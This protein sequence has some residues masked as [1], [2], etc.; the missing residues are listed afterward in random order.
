M[1]IAGA[2][3]QE[4][5]QC[6]WVRSQSASILRV[7]GEVDL[8][9]VYMLR[10][11]L[12]HAWGYGSPVIVDLTNVTYIDSV[13]LVALMQFD[14]QCSHGGRT[15]MAVVFESQFLRNLFSVRSIQIP[16]QIFP[17]VETAASVLVEQ[18]P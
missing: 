16:F 14:E 10:D 17:D 13:G 2:R 7:R 5:L 15:R 8:S 6:K 18:T 3:S 9:N 4:P 11:S 1:R 12:D